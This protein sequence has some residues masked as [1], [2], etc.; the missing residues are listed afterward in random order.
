MLLDPNEM[1]S[2]GTIALKSLD[3]SFDNN[4][5]AYCFYESGSDWGNVKIRNVETGI[6]YPETLE[7]VKF[8]RTSWTKD[9]KGFFY[10]VSF[11]L[12]L[13]ALWFNN[14][15]WFY[16]QRYPGSGD[17]TETDKNENQKIYYHRV[18]EPQEK[19][20]LIAEFKENPTWRV[21]VRTIANFMSFRRESEHSFNFQMNF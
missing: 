18:G 2:D 10:S 11:S 1:S 4:L 20:T 6:D 12:N 7:G 3:F 8:S 17:G 21:Y 9:N 14:F 5:L 13:V 19:D 15:F 16:F